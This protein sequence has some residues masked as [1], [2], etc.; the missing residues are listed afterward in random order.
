MLNSVS[1][2]EKITKRKV[3]VYKSHIDPKG[4]REIAEK[5]KTQLFR[6]FVLMKPRPDEVQIVSIEKYFE[7][8]VVVDGEYCIEYSKKWTRNIQVDDTMQELTFF[9][10]KIK[11]TSLKDHLKTPCK[12]VKI[13]GE[14]RYKFESKAHLIFDSQWREV[15]FEE[16]PFV[17]FE[18]QPETVLNTVDQNS[19]KHMMSGRKEVEI[20]KSR[21][22]RRP[23][24]I[25]T[26]YH[27]MFEVSE[28]VL[29]Y[30]P[31]YKVKVQ[32]TKT[33]KT[34]TLIIDAITGKTSSVSKPKAAP[35]KKKAIKKPILPSSPKTATPKDPVPVHIPK[36][37]KGS[38]LAK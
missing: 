3:I 7:P 27:E 33:Q 13:N 26:V 8:Y 2:P 11:T 19:G 38:K 30:K 31:M 32:N 29:V 36:S 21:I 4:V 10:I 25:L 15:G 35:K 24:E 23:T 17:P 28:R 20:L 5:T 9:G 37:K 6:K 22:V 18:E 14:G 1:L 34:I 16:L 12:I